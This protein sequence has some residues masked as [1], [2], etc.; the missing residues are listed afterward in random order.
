M[1]GEFL[2][3][4]D[5]ARTLHLYQEM[6]LAL[7]HKDGAGAGKAK[8]PNVSMLISTAQCRVHDLGVKTRKTALK[9][10]LRMRFP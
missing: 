2:S 4:K 8:L 10:E 5:W 1:L 7:V 6:T 9:H 3:S